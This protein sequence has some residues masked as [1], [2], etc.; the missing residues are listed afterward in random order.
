MLNKKLL[1]TIFALSTL[2]VPQGAWADDIDVS[3]Q[4]SW[5]GCQSAIITGGTT[6]KLSGVDVVLG[7]TDMSWGETK[8]AKTTYGVAT[9]M[10]NNGTNGINSFTTSSSLPT[11]GG[12]LKI[13]P[14]ADG[15]ITISGIESRTPGQNILFVSLNDDN[16]TIKAVYPLPYTSTANTTTNRSY[17]VE[18]GKTYYFFQLA[19][20]NGT[21]DYK[22]SRYILKSISFASGDIV[23]E[24]SEYKMWNF[25]EET[26]TWK[27]RTIPNNYDGLAVKGLVTMDEENG[28]LQV[29]KSAD[30]SFSFKAATT[31]YLV[32][33]GKSN[34]KGGK[35][36]SLTIDG[37]EERILKT[38]AGTVFAREI[39][40]TS[41]SKLI[42]I[43]A[44]ADHGLDVFSISFVPSNS[45]W[46]TNT[47]SVTLD[48]RGYATFYPKWHVKFTYN[49]S[50]NNFKAYYLTAASVG[51]AVTAT[52]LNSTNTYTIPANTPVLIVGEG[53]TTLSLTK[54]SA[55]EVA[56]YSY[57]AAAS[58][59]INNQTILTILH[60]AYKSGMTLYGSTGSV[61]YYAYKKNAGCFAKVT[62]DVTIPDGKGYFTLPK[63]QEAR[64][65][66]INFEDGETTGISTARMN[67]EEM[68]PV[69]FD[70]S[71]RRVAQPVRGIYIVNG[72]KV[73]IK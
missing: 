45:T 15:V 41:G 52:A 5:N 68:N 23:S 34:G 71:G 11:N 44:N 42:T 73:V 6:L 8:D 22:S 49:A 55:E 29:A 10:I 27:Y 60:A 43:A 48:D 24:I 56:P 39:S 57:N 47:T 66:T 36:I 7:G 20:G 40:V 2:L 59:K 33:H 12:F 21:D 31:G 67:N 16:T 64:D 19:K 9:F 26:D 65:L 70:L 38:L 63:S 69:Y 62:A 32:I 17:F 18:N 13:N 72:K 28:R 46:A 51:S 58:A 4:T 35:G 1:S 3:S 30:G 25:L 53:G 61:D 14:S 50:T 37:T 54:T